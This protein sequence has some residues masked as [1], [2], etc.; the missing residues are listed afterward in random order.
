MAMIA[1][2]SDNHSEPTNTTAD[3]WFGKTSDIVTTVGFKNLL[4]S[5]KNLQ[6]IVGNKLNP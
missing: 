5:A 4:M 3:Y 1:V 2:Y 6:F